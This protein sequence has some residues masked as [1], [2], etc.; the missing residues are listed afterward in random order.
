MSFN[1]MLFGCM[2]VIS[3]VITFVSIVIHF[4]EI[5]YGC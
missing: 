2:C 4:I 5:T 3:V 1:T